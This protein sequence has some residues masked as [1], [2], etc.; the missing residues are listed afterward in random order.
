MALRDDGSGN[1]LAHEEGQILFKGGKV[2]HGTEAVTCEFAHNGV[3]DERGGEVVRPARNVA[4]KV[5]G[6][7]AGCGLKARAKKVLAQ[8][9]A[10]LA[11]PDR[12]NDGFAEFGFA[13]FGK[14]VGAIA[15][16]A[17]AGA[18]QGIHL[19]NGAGRL[20]ELD[21]DAQPGELDRMPA[22]QVVPGGFGVDEGHVARVQVD[23]GAHVLK[24]ASL[25]GLGVELA[26]ERQE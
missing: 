26:D 19:V 1:A 23:V 6:G 17:P 24:R 4:N 10:H 13:G 21:G 14:R 16:V 11:A 3:V 20:K 15:G 2:A 22:A 9:L 7:F 8:L 18:Q 25:P 5:L 12:L